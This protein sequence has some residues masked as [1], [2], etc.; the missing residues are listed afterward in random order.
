MLRR[1]VAQAAADAD[2]GRV[3]QDVEPPVGLG[4]LAHE[5]LAV[6]LARHVDGDRRRVE[7][8]GRSLDLLARA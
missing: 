3:H 1:E 8:P 5:P 4:V 6:L 2:P 7:L